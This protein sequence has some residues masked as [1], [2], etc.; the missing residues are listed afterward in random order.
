MRRAQRALLRRQIPSIKRSSV[1]DC[2][3]GPQTDGSRGWSEGKGGGLEFVKVWGSRDGGCC[4][5]PYGGVSP[6]TDSHLAHVKPRAIFLVGAVALCG[7][8]AVNSQ[9]DIQKWLLPSSVSDVREQE[10]LIEMRSAHYNEDGRRRLDQGGSQPFSIEISWLFNTVSKPVFGAAMR[11]VCG[12]NPYVIRTITRVVVSHKFRIYIYIYSVHSGSYAICGF[13]LRYAKRRQQHTITTYEIRQ[14]GPI[15]PSSFSCPTFRVL[16]GGAK[17]VEYPF[18]VAGV[19]T[20]P[21][22]LPVHPTALPRHF[23]F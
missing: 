4:G 16:G 23:V 10:R 9:V 7:A 5:L 8:D 2:Y 6:I 18:V 15:K 19:R 20:L 13:G 12:C 1:G 21:T 11:L 17:L 22:T 14:L 3:G